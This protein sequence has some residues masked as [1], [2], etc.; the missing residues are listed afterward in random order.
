MLTAHGQ[1]LDDILWIC[2][3]QLLEQQLSSRP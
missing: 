1:E 2:G 3:A